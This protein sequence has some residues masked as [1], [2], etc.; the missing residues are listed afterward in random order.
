MELL[1][2]L[3]GLALAI[4]VIAGS[5]FGYT[6]AVRSVNN[7]AELKYSHRPVN[8]LNGFILLIPLGV[9]LLGLALGQNDISNVYVGTTIALIGVFAIMWSVAKKSDWGIA[10][11]TILLLSVGIVLSVILVLAFIFMF[12]GSTNKDK[13]KK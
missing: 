6:G 8:I 12:S 1:N 3:F 9:F 7:A 11:L 10:V 5:Y 4:G 13:K 2:L